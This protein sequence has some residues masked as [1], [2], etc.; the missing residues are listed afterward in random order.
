MPA[1]D[2]RPIRR[3][4]VSVSDKTGLID[5]ARALAA[6][7]VMLLSTGGTARSLREAGLAVTDVSDVTGFPEIMDGRVKTLHPAIH[8]GLL[9]VRGNA[10]HDKA[11]AAHGITDIDLLVVNLYPFEETVAKGGSDADVIENIDVGG[12]AMIRAAAK[13]HDSVA[14][15]VSPSAYALV[16][17]DMEK[18]DGATTRATRTALAAH[19]FARTASYD[20]AIAGWMQRRSGDVLPARLVLAGERQ[21]DLRY[22]ENPHQRAALYRSVDGRIG[23]MEAR[24]VQGKE[25][26]Y[27]NIN[28]A[29]AALE[30]VADLPPGEPACVIV[31]HGN[32]CGV[33]R[34][35]SLSEAYGKALACDPVSAFGGILAFNQTLDGETAKAISQIFTEVILAPGASDEALAI[36]SAK[37][38]LRLLLL[39]RLPDPRAAS[40]VVKSVA[41]GFLAQTRDVENGQMG[42]TI[43]SKRQPTATEEADLRFAWA[44]AKHVKSNAIIFAKGG[45]TMGI[46]AGQMS[47]IDSTRIAVSKSRDAATAMGLSEPLVKGAVLA[48]DAFFP[49]PDG[50]EAAAD[51]GATAIVQPGGAMKDQDVIAA[52]DARGLAMVFTGQRHFRH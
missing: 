34:G 46:G 31:K 6:R 23:L 3:A 21:L 15:V 20:A 41:G 12:P 36:L 25:L 17:A 19:A 4:L 26:S 37:K 27:N 51:A 49:F 29:D 24:Q 39:P 47:R 48:S 11:K 42:W 13:N 22:G 50:I 2:L 44:V 43:V 18:H 45:A 40:V 38:N 7:K 16:L 52:A 30:C 1:S 28:D 9:A 10:E 33:A 5:F 32:P 35:Q 14:V 8:G